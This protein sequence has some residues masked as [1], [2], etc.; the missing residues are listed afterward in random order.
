MSRKGENIFRR[1][2]GRWEARYIKGRDCSGKALY[3]YCYAR[4]YR[5]AK[6]KVTKVKAALAEGWTA[7]GGSGRTL[8]YYCDLWLDRK[9]QQVKEST[10]MKYGMIVEKHLKPALGSCPLEA[11]T[12]QRIQAFSWE[13]LQD[14]QLSPKT[15]R[16]ILVLLGAVLDYM[17]KE[18]T[19]KGSAVEIFYPREEKKQPRVLSREEQ[20]RLIAYLLEDMDLCKLGSMLALLTGI[21]I[22]E[23]CALRWSDL[24]TEDRCLRVSATVQ[25]LKNR[26]GEGARTR[27]VLQPPKTGASVRNIPMTEYALQ[28][29]EKMR[30]E[31]PHAFILTGTDSFMDPRTL[32]YRMQR[33]IEACGL[34]GVHFHTLRHTFA[35]RCAEVGFE[36]KS[37][38]EVLGHASTSITLKRYVHSSLELKRCNMQKLAAVGL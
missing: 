16:D 37:L 6:E 29:C 5:D 4:S 25:R 19:G 26:E 1:K 21:R 38:S 30:P 14:R 11:V 23:L 20:S 13:L 10:Y 32:Q 9:A 12:A 28:L 8:A 33:Y 3:G 17:S 18:I 31:N 34:E 35:T 27:L 36:I 7:A 22:G 2:D 15:V 24:S